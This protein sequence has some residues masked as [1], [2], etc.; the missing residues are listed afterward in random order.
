MNVMSRSPLAAPN[1][2]AVVEDVIGLEAFRAKNCAATLWNRQIPQEIL[3][4]MNAIDPDALPVGRCIVR[5]V[6]TGP[7]V[8]SFCDKVGLPKGPER[9]WFEQDVAS[10]AGIFSDLMRTPHIRLR[11]DM[12]TTN[13]C[14][15]FH[16]DAIVGRL[17]C[18]YRGPGTQYGTGQNGKD[19]NRVFTV[20]TGAPIL[21][22]G[23]LWPETPRSGLLHRSPPIETTG[24]TRLV[25]VLDPMNHPEN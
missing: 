14:R 16:V 15:K 22:R 2:V 8:R 13:A 21:L 6:E 24:E 10:L 12:V 25:V 19:P 20:P 4:W 1:G 9:S 17:V 11:M 23:S 18:S 3:K 7:M 5:A